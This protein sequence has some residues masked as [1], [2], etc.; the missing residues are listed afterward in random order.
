LLNIGI[1]TGELMAYNDRIKI[2]IKDLSGTWTQVGMTLNEEQSVSSEMKQA[3]E[4]FPD[5][6]VRA[7]DKDGRVVDILP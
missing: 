5:R 6:P 2:E 1:R 4:R 7:V 3:K